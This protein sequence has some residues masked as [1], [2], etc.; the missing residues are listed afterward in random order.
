MLHDGILESRWVFQE[1]IPGF[2]FCLIAAGDLVANRNISDSRKQ[3]RNF[4]EEQWVG[5][6]TTGWQEALAGAGPTGSDHPL[7]GGALI[8]ALQGPSYN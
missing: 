7:G 6:G 5:H 2:E 3:K 4:C 8:A 1:V